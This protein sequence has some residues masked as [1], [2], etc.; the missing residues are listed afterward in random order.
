MAYKVVA[1]RALVQGVIAGVHYNHE[2]DEN[3]IQTAYEEKASQD[4]NHTVDTTD[5]TDMRY[6]SNG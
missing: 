5:T 6:N 1:Y 4:T 2:R 3:L